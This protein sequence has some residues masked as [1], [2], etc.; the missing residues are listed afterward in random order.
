MFCFPYSLAFGGVHLFFISYHQAV[1]KREHHTLTHK[2]TQSKKK[3]S[4][5]CSN[6]FFAIVVVV[7]AAARVL[8]MYSLAVRT[9]LP[10]QCK[11]N[12][13]IDQF[14]SFAL[15]LLLFIVSSFIN[16]CA[17]VGF[18]FRREQRK[19]MSATRPHVSFSI[20]FTL[21]FKLPFSLL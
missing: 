9:L 11:S 17:S 1:V 14:S 8:S 21:A 6:L 15:G 5:I 20:S 3:S 16:L 12:H 4:F 10:E 13:I 2:I 7:A 18:E 19:Y